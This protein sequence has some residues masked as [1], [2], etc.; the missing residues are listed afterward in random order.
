MKHKLLLPALFLFYSITGYSQSINLKWPSGNYR[1]VVSATQD[2]KGQI[3]PASINMSLYPDGNF[4]F[5]LFDRSY[6]TE[7]RGL[8]KIA[9]SGT[10]QAFNQ[11][12][13]HF[14]FSEPFPS[15]LQLSYKTGK[16]ADEKPIP[17]RID[18]NDRVS[19]SNVLIY[20]GNS[21]DST[22][23]KSLSEMPI[24]SNS[25]DEEQYTINRADSLY[26]QINHYDEATRY[27]YAIPKDASSFDLKMDENASI[28][29]DLKSLKGFK[30]SADN[31]MYLLIRN[32][33]II[34]VYYIGAAKE[35]ERSVAVNTTQKSTVL[36][37]ASEYTFSIYDSSQVAVDTVADAAPY[38][39]TKSGDSVHYYTSWKEATEKAK[40]EGKF[41][42]LY[43]EPKKCKSCD[44]TFKETLAGVNESSY[45]NY[46]DSFNKHFVLYLAKDTVRYLFRQYDIT[47]FPA[48]VVLNTEM[49]PLYIANGVDIYTQKNVLFG[50][51]SKDFYNKL[52][53]SEQT[54]KLAADIE[55]QNYPRP[56]I[57]AYLQLQKKALEMDD[58]YENT[59]EDKNS[60]YTFFPGMSYDTIRINKYWDVLKTKYHV[61]D[62]PDTAIANLLLA[63]NFNNNTAGMDVI[64]P[65][66]H[67]GNDTTWKTSDVF[68]YLTHFY[69]ELAPQ[70]VTTHEKNENEYTEDEPSLYEK[71]SRIITAMYGSI[72]NSPEQLRAALMAHKQFTN[73][74]E[75]LMQMASPLY[76][77]YLLYYTD[78]LQMQNET[79][80]AAAA[81]CDQ[82][83]VND[84]RMTAKNIVN[85]LLTKS[86]AA[87]E[88]AIAQNGRYT[89]DMNNIPETPAEQYAATVAN[90]LNSCAWGVYTHKRTGL[91][92]DKAIKWSV[93]SLAFEPENPYYLDT[94]AHF[95][96]QSGKKKEGIAKE[97]EALNSALNKK[98]KY[99]VTKEELQTMKDEMQKMKT[100]KL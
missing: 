36:K 29:N 55:K 37:A 22:Q 23:W 16:I 82:F 28:Y 18:L 26:I 93:A 33:S 87:T 94:Y 44:A 98:S 48:I 96:Y 34:A 78:T 80:L 47:R 41:L 17:V 72:D 5:T 9:F 95:L 27:A 85:D 99:Y 68:V 53:T 74:S 4:T 90:V 8:K 67:A 63:Y 49:K 64:T 2:D 84:P 91:I 30:G 11:D 32:S 65:E 86:K 35:N 42:V 13:V 15:Q 45:N 3:N 38:E 100:G 6:N 56:A 14:N 1:L 79:D 61:L 51:Y 40:R 81:F 31:E 43:N 88:Y 73:A 59:P 75:D 54:A 97:Q 39:Y 60:A 25:G 20:A 7:E 92:A 70:M 76:I 71:L 46:T 89:I 21:F 50:Y 57:E 83:T 52:I 62:K 58:N 69:N 10:Y 19:S 77:K 66:V 24:T 12:S